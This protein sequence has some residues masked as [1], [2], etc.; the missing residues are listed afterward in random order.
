MFSL[1][2]NKETLVCRAL[3]DAFE[4]ASQGSALPPALQKHLSACSQCRLFVDEIAKTRALFGTLPSRRFEP[5]PWFVG[6]V[7]SAINAREAELRRSTD[8]WTLIP[9]LATK[10]A[11]VS[12]LALVL[13]GTWIYER[14]KATAAP[15]QTDATAGES[16]FEAPS[17]AVPDD[18]LASV[19]EQ[20]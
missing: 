19:G 18:L 15:H 4:Q 11:W 17:Q 8:T 6:R 13:A 10:L 16:L 14:P 9:R 1:R 12:A 3:R 5:S 2:R 7:M 20:D